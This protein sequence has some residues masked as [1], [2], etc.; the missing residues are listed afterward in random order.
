[1]PPAGCVGFLTQ[2]SL[3]DVLWSAR[4]PCRVSVSD[5]PPVLSLPGALSITL[6]RAANRQVGDR[7]HPHRPFLVQLRRGWFH[8]LLTL[9][10]PRSFPG[11]PR[12]S[13]NRDTATYLRFARYPCQVTVSDSPPSLTPLRAPVL[14]LPGAAEAAWL[15][16]VVRLQPHRTTLVRL[17]R[18][19]IRSCLT[20]RGPVLRP[21]PTSGFS[22]PRHCG[23]LWSA[24]YPC[25]IT[26]PDS[27]PGLTPP[28][29]AGSLAH[30]GGRARAQ[31]V[32]TPS[33]S[34][35]T[36]LFPLRRTTVVVSSSRDSGRASGPPRF[37]PQPRY[38]DVTV[39]RN[40]TPA[41][42]RFLAARRL[43][44]Y[45]GAPVVSPTGSADVAVDGAQYSPTPKECQPQIFV[46]ATGAEFDRINLSDLFRAFGPTFTTHSPTC[47]PATA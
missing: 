37:S 34:S 47:S 19:T 6:D 26:V 29:C 17:R 1:M 43:Y 7:L 30:R 45:A 13:R 5:R 10:V 44:R 32:S 2:P 12:C 21:R 9:A 3:C 42:S 14:S 38:C 41:R 39:V 35:F 4:Y 8:P 20:P 24:R 27:P 28:R 18:G 22:Q 31:Q 16:S 11:P 40:V 33:S 15:P 23:V 46:R 36:R 25:Q